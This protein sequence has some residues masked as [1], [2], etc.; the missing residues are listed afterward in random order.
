MDAPDLVVKVDR[1]K[2]GHQG[3]NISQVAILKYP[4]NHPLR[5]VMKIRRSQ[6]VIPKQ[7]L[8]L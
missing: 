7:A 1:T 3:S 2:P 4:L 6:R 5:I 8:I